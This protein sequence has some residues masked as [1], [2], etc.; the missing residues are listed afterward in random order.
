[1]GVMRCERRGCSR[2]M[3]DE[4]LRLG[5]GDERYICYSCLSELRAEQDRWPGT[6]TVQQMIDRVKDFFSTGGSEVLDG[7]EA[8]SDAFERLVRGGD[9]P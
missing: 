4:L 7:R 6:M 3:C 5:D 2:I 9:G 1:M 8:I